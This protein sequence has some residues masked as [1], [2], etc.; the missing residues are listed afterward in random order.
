M[1][2]ICLARVPIAGARHCSALSPSLVATI[3]NENRANQEQADH[4]S[5]TIAIDTRKALLAQCDGVASCRSRTQLTNR[6]IFGRDF[7]EQRTKRSMACIRG[8]HMSLAMFCMFQYLASL[9]FNNP[10]HAAGVWSDCSSFYTEMQKSSMSSM[11]P[12]S[13]TTCKF[14]INKELLRREEMKLLNDF[15]KNPSN[16]YGSLSLPSSELAKHA[17]AVKIGKER[18]SAYKNPAAFASNQKRIIWPYYKRA[19]PLP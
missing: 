15:V 7:D 13:I 18:I 2:T 12:Q 3:G 14:V 16:G 17:M 6:S 10:T 19:S 1:P 8:S 5:E 9:C 4:L 11:E